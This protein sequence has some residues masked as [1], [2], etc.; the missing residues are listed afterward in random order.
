MIYLKWTPRS[1]IINPRYHETTN[2][3][4]LEQISDKILPCL[5]FPT[6]DNNDF[7]CHAASCYFR[8]WAIYNIQ[9]SFYKRV[10]TKFQ[11]EKAHG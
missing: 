11:R 2:T 7:Q 1:I 9:I 3:P 6:N 5:S 4:F 10:K 8:F